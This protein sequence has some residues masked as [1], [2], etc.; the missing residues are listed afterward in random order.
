MPIANDVR[1]DGQDR[2][3][4][5]RRKWLWRKDCVKNFVDLR[6]ASLRGIEEHA[7]R[8]GAKQ[9]DRNQR[10]DAVKGQPGGEEQDIVFGQLFGD[11]RYVITDSRKNS[12]HLHDN[13]LKLLV[14]MAR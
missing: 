6:N 4:D 13:L 2:F 10:Q 12:K 7:Q 5:T 3:L 1:N 8:R 14:Q 11:A 9:Q